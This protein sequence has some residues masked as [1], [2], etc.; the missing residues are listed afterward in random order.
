[1]S[2][3][4]SK[5]GSTEWRSVTGRS[6]CIKEIE[7]T[8]ERWETLAASAAKMTRSEEKAMARYIPTS[9]MVDFIV[10]TSLR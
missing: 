2:R 3:E 10:P 5:L 4:G 9:S 7:R 1:M 6:M 8:V